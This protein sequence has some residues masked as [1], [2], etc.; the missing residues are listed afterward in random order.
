MS[1]FKKKCLT[2]LSIVFFSSHAIAAPAL[3]LDSTEDTPIGFSYKNNWFA[4]KT[5]NTNAVLELLKPKQL[6]KANWA[7]GIELA[8]S[9][10]FTDKK[11]YPVFITPPVNGWTFVVG[12]NLPT[13][14]EQTPHGTDNKIAK[15]INGSFFD[16]FRV[17]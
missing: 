1:V 3:H 17:C 8:Y 12:N 11:Q 13:P 14:M 6:T 2:F 16:L 7:S 9:H 4:I 15:K 10:D 5:T